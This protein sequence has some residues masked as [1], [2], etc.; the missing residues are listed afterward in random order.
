MSIKSNSAEYMVEL[1]DKTGVAVSSVSDGYVL[2][3]TKSHIEG[4]LKTL[5]DNGS[6]RCVVFVKNPEPPATQN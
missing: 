5:N 1:A 3:F 2:I 6:D 4:M